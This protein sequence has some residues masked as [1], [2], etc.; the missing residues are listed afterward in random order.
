MFVTEY[1]ND[2]DGGHDVPRRARGAG[3]AKRKAAIVRK[4]CSGGIRKRRG[5]QALIPSAWRRSEPGENRIS[6][7]GVWRRG[8]RRSAIR[9]NREG[10]TEW[11]RPYRVLS[12]PSNGTASRVS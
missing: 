3:V 9:A 12:V 8:D 7:L 11:H 10:L 6:N 4:L 5:V 2:N 1:A